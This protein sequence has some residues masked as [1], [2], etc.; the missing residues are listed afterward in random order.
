MFAKK[1]YLFKKE[2]KAQFSDGGTTGPA[3]KARTQNKFSEK[4]EMPR[5]QII[6]RK[7][8]FQGRDADFSK[9][10]YNKIVTEGYDKT[11]DPLVVWY[12]KKDKKY[13][14]LAGHSRWAASETLYKRGNKSLAN[15]PV[16]I[17]NGDKEEA[18]FYAVVE[19]NRKGTAETFKEDLKTYKLVVKQGYN[20]DVLKGIFTPE[21][22][23]NTLQK[24][25]LLN[26]NGPF[27]QYI[28][29]DQ[30]KSFPYLE[31]NAKWTAEYRKMY[32]D[33]F[34]DSHEQELFDYFYKSQKGLKIYKPDLTNKLQNIIQSLDYDKTKAFG[35]NKTKSTRPQSAA[36][37]QIKYYNKI[38]KE[39]ELQRK[40]K[41]LKIAE[42][43]AKTI[44]EL[45][46]IGIEKQPT[47]DRLSSQIKDANKA[48]LLKL[49]KVN[50]LKSQVVKAD[51][52]AAEAPN[53][54]FNPAPAPKVATKPKTLLKIDA[55]VLK[56]H[57]LTFGKQKF[58]KGG[59]TETEKEAWQMTKDEYAN[60]Y[61]NKVAEKLK[62]L[63]PEDLLKRHKFGKS[64]EWSRID[65][66]GYSPGSSLSKTKSK[67][68][69]D[70]N[71]HIKLMKEYA[72][73][74]RKRDNQQSIIKAL[75]YDDIEKGKY[76]N[77]DYSKK[78]NLYKKAIANNEMTAQRATEIIKSA[79]LEVPN[80][81]EE[82]NTEKEGYKLYKSLD[83]AHAFKNEIEKRKQVGINDRFL[84]DDW[85]E[86]LSFRVPYTYSIGVNTYMPSYNKEKMLYE[87][88]ERIQPKQKGKIKTVTKI[89]KS[90]DFL[91]TYEE[92]LKES[93]ENL[94]L[95]KSQ[96]AWFQ[97]YANF[98]VTSSQGTTYKGDVKKTGE[99]V[100]NYT[101]F[102]VTKS[103]LKKYGK[104]AYSNLIKH[105]ISEN[106][107]QRAIDEGFI[108]VSRATEI[109][110][111]AGLQVPKELK[112]KRTNLDQE[113]KELY[114]LTMPKELFKQGGSI[115]P[116]F[117]YKPNL[118]PV[119]KI[120]E[121]ELIP[122]L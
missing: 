101:L 86:G 8:M 98:E 88:W 67:T 120:S 53:L 24:L 80:E 83:N 50:S 26:D 7:D 68:I 21:S 63:T 30:E 97:R 113:V 66:F 32:G 81:L 47:I 103:D 74:V 112:N 106:K 100:N 52:I 58:E 35:L 114:N 11:D 29:T 12:S 109:I 105:S 61:K 76:V 78:E 62:D 57:E 28:G 85:T 55:K 34:T 3:G 119:I 42:L 2:Y 92:L 75:G 89:Y 1:P 84:N 60:Y 111:S 9:D 72:D 87:I 43:Q 107:F 69:D 40:S 115:D 104:E 38:I 93:I 95:F 54:F 90:S 23:L 82:K 49:E 39:L 41:E 70:I 64:V 94:Y 46:Q 116:D 59:I 13:L 22:K 36:E 37:E 10:T 99:V 110:K 122:E 71:Y 65:I 6:V 77:Y 20:R 14:I 4:T 96:P 18:I 91:K 121:T 108:D 33:K 17:F 56:V 51:S 44:E 31:R 27:V 118:E 79:G 16:K 48:I 5:G 102:K 45:A 15:M 117:L 19:S 73:G 25:A